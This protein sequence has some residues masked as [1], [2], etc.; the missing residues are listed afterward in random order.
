MIEVVH[1]SRGTQ[2]NEALPELV[3][4]MRRVKWID[5][6]ITRCEDSIAMCDSTKYRCTSKISSGPRGGT[7][8]ALEEMMQQEAELRER[9][10]ILSAEKVKLLQDISK[11]PS[12][13][14][15]D[16]EEYKVLLLYYRGGYS[17]RQIASVLY[18]S[19]GTAD[20]RRKS[21]I[22]KLN[23]I[24]KHWTTLDTLGHST[25]V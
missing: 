10:D 9:I 22:N 25:M 7:R 4:D 18:M 14:V 13:S 17:L 24:K 21:G 15:L 8:K 12:A 5:D 6:E 20:N 3:Q 19:K 16:P 2:S 23:R 11:S 1:Y